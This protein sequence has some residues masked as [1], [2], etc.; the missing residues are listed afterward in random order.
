[1]KLYQSVKAAVPLRAAAERYG[2]RT[3]WSGMSR[4]LFHEDH[5][6]SMKLNEDYFYCF[7]CGTF[8]D[9]IDL[10]AAIFQI[11][12]FDAA[13]KLARDFHVRVDRE[14]PPGKEESPPLPKG[15]MAD[16]EKREQL[17]TCLRVLCEYQR[18]LRKWKETY[19][20]KSPDEPPDDRYVE[21]CQ[22]Y[23]RI[24]DLTEGLTVGTDDQRARALALVTADN[25]ITLLAERLE[26]IR[27]EEAAVAKTTEEASKPA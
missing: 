7:G 10:T 5:S 9:V 14:L 12:A 24:D 25:K 17:W 16:R 8:G 19:R 26:R 18:L 21:A 3:N 2:L 27:K 13:L 4:C 6:P 15:L 11:P 1:M 20:P 22:M 23:D